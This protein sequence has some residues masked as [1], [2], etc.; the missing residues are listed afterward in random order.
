MWVIHDFPAYG[1]MDGCT[2]KGYNACPICGRNT[3]SEY[4]NCGKKCV[5]MGH[6]KFLLQHHKFRS[7]KALFNGK[8]EHHYA[9][10]IVKVSDILKQTKGKEAI[11]GKIESN[12]RK[13]NNKTG[14]KT[15]VV[16]WKKQSI[17]FNLPYWEVCR[18]INH[19]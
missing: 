12:K 10:P 3:E 8:E 9:P 2:T 16:V 14:E 7:Q 15:D 18:P 19:D 13:R 5:Y 17:L 6:R 11:W 4:L 1:N